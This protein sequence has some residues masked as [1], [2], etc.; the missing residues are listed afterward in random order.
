M[1]AI[2]SRSVSGGSGVFAWGANWRGQLGI[3]NKDA[4]FTPRE[5]SLNED[6]FE[7]V[8]CGRDFSL[9][10]ST[11]ARK[12][13]VWGNFKYVGLT[14]SQDLESPFVFKPL[15]GKRIASI[16]CSDSMCAAVSENNDVYVWGLWFNELAEQNQSGKLEM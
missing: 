10:L 7:E 8:R 5:I 16:S 3:G 9:G 4:S 12:V 13:Y 6:T 1:M 15:D 14:L 11:K 2:C